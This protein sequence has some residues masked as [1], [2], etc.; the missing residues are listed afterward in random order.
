VN[1]NKTDV[2]RKIVVVAMGTAYIAVGVMSILT[3][4]VTV[5]RQV[6]K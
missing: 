3:G 1:L 2:A 6:Q 4:V 5:A